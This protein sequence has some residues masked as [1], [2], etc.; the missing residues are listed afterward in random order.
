MNR[1]S[2]EKR[3]ELLHYAVYGRG[4][5]LNNKIAKQEIQCFFGLCRDAEVLENLLQFRLDNHL[6]DE[7]KVECYLYVL[8]VLSNY[9]CAVIEEQRERLAK[10]YL[11]P[12]TTYEERHAALVQYA[13]R[14]RNEARHRCSYQYQFVQKVDNSLAARMERAAKRH[15]WD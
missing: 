5:T 2:V 7:E 12:T 13:M 11:T 6:V 14:R 15:G 9:I 8:G 1:L 10:R 3:R 4:C